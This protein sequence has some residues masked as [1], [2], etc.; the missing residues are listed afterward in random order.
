MG[1]EVG[2]AQPSPITPKTH[3]DKRWQKP[4]TYAFARQNA[5]V[6]LTLLDLSKA[7]MEMPVVFFRQKGAYHLAALLGRDKNENLFVDSEGK[8]QVQY[9][10]ALLKGYPFRMAQDKES[11]Y[12]LCVDEESGL[13]GEKGN[14]FVDEEGKPT[15]KVR[16]MGKFLRQAEQSRMAAVKACQVL[17]ESGLIQPLP[18]MAG[19]Y[20]IDKEKLSQV[21]DESL[22]ELH[23]SWAQFVAHCQIISTQ[24]LKRLEKMGE[25][26]VDFDE[27]DWDKI[28]I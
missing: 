12:I 4:K 24:H 28:K 17:D 16:A 9:V 11:R 8:W 26:E 25:Q 14:R 7:V 6:P 23:K 20:G 21:P 2:M 5:L 10:P 1:F 13:V 19:L 15:Q 3:S 22:P 18:K 27:I